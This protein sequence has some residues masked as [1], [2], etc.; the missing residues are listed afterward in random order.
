MYRVSLIDGLPILASD[1]ADATTKD[2]ILLQVLQYTL[3]RW[4]RRVVPLLVFVDEIGM[5]C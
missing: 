5:K 3:E 1:I 2:P 4:H